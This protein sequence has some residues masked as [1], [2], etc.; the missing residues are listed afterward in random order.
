MSRS[1]HVV[2]RAGETERKGQMVTYLLEL[3][4]QLC[5]NKSHV[6]SESSG[7]EVPLYSFGTF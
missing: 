4:I 7:F 6:I 1:N 5:M 2:C 3:S